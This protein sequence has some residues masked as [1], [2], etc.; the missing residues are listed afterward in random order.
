MSRTDDVQL[1]KS[2][3]IYDLEPTTY[4]STRVESIRSWKLARRLG[5]L[6]LDDSLVLTVDS[7]CLSVICREGG[8]RL[9]WLSLD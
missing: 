9:C 5:A 8:L 7:G 6:D 4:A 1:T 3:E 2:T